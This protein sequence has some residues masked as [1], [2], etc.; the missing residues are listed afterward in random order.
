MTSLERIG[1]SSSS[2]CH[3]LLTIAS[4]MKKNTKIG[5]RGTS[6]ATAI[7]LRLSWLSPN[8]EELVALQGREEPLGSP[9][10]ARSSTCLQLRPCSAVKSH[11]NNTY[12][13]PKSSSSPVFPA[14]CLSIR[15]HKC[16]GNN[17]MVNYIPFRSLGHRSSCT[18]GYG[19]FF[20]S[21]EVWTL[22]CQHQTHT[23]H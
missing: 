6:Q 2:K 21:R 20:H 3:F 14:S 17:V 11:K 7:S 10:V 23:L 9:P 16:K 8:T 13:E 4:V 5:D 1:P 18:F 12:F 19:D 22:L 15:Q